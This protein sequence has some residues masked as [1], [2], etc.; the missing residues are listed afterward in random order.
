MPLPLRP[1]GVRGDPGGPEGHSEIAAQGLLAFDRLEQRLEVPLAEAARTVA[2]DHLEEERGAI[3]RGLREDLEEVA[4]LVAVGQDPQ[5]AQVVPV[6]ADLADTIQ[7]VLVVRV[8]RREEDDSLL[9]QRLDRANDVLR[10]QR[11]VLDAWPTEELEVF[12]DLALALALSRLVDR[13][14]DLSLAVRHDLGHQGR[15]LGVD[16]LV[17]EVDD[18]R[19]AHRP[20]V[21]LDPVIHASELDVADD[22]VD[23]PQ[24]DTA[25][26]GT[27]VRAHD[28]VKAGE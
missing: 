7:G 23:R 9:L 25:D 24:A 8:G 2:L 27:A 15:V 11:D 21:E 18:V 13:E 1:C 12:L 28:F 3:L 10:L 16:L 5:A 4:V 22:V 20:L 19:E 26:W 17:R 6:L 14:L